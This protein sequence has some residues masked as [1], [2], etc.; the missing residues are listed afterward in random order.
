LEVGLVSTDVITT[1]T[2]TEQAGILE[3]MPRLDYSGGAS[4]PSLLL[5]PQ[6]SNLVTQS[7]YIGAWTESALT[8]TDNN[9]TSPEG[10]LNAAKLTLPSGSATKRIALGSMPVTAVARSYSFFVKSNDITAVQL[11]HSGDLQGYARFDISTGVVGSS[12][13]KTTSNIEDYGNGW[14]RCIANF[15]SSNAFGSTIYLYISDSATGSYG[16]STSAEGDLFVYGAQYEEGSYP[17]S[18]IPTYGSSVTKSKDSFQ[19]NLQSQGIFDGSDTEGVLMVEYEKPNTLENVDLMRFMGASAV[20]RAFI[21]NSGV[22]FAVDWSGISSGVIDHDSNNKTLWRLN[23]LSTGNVFHNGTKLTGN[24]TGT[25]WS[26][27]RLLRF[28]MEGAGGVLRIKQILLFP[29]ALTDAECIELTT[30]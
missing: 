25:A 8:I 11:V 28:N 13:T 9:A 5:E 18:Y 16:G 27:I 26:D 29:T 19:M 21:Y 1:T 14:Y 20:G 2:T 3:D 12:G 23:S 24:S 10:V 7:E 6:R 30:I 22:N 4:C 15:D 17:T